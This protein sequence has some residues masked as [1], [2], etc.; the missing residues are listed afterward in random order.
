MRKF[1]I[2]FFVLFAFMSANNVNAQDETNYFLNDYFYYEITDE[3][4]AEVALYTYDYNYVGSLPEMCIVPATVTDPNTSKVYNVTT[5]KNN[6]FYWSP[7]QGI[8]FKGPI[9]RVGDQ[10]FYNCS[11]EKVVFEQAVDTIG[12]R[13]FYYDRALQDVTFNS[14]LKVLCDEAF[15]YSSVQNLTLP[16]GLDSIGER[17]FTYT[18]LKNIV[19]PEGFSKIGKYMFSQCYDLESITIPGTVKVVSPY[20]FYGC[21]KLQFTLEEGVEELGEEAFHGNCTETIVLPSTITKLGYRCLASGSGHKRIVAKMQNPPMCDG[22]DYDVYENIICDVPD[23]RLQAYI[24]QGWD[25][26]KY[27]KEISQ[28]DPVFFVADGLRYHALDDATCEL[29]KSEDGWYSLEEA[30]LTIP[31]EVTDPNTNKS[32]KVV[33]L[34]R[35]CLNGASMTSLTLPEGLVRIEYGAMENCNNMQEVNF[36]STLKE[37]GGYSFAFSGIKEANLNNGIETVESGAFVRCMNLTSAV[38]PASLVDEYEMGVDYEGNPEKIKVKG[39]LYGAFAMNDNLKAVTSYITDPHDDYIFREL[40]DSAVLT[41]PTGLLDKYCA[42]ASEIS[43]GAFDIIQDMSGRKAC[44]LTIEGGWQGSYTVNGVPVTDNYSAFLP[45]GTELTIVITPNEDIYLLD[46]IWLG[47]ENITSQ[48]DGNTIVIIIDGGIQKIRFNF[49]EQFILKAPI[50]TYSSAYGLDLTGNEDVAA[51][52]AKGFEDNDVL[53]ERVDKVYPGMGVLLVGTVGTTVP[54]VVDPDW[55][56]FT[57][58]NLMRSCWNWGNFVSASSWTS[59]GNTKNYVLT[60]DPE[61]DYAYYFTEVVTSATL[62][63]R[64]AF[65]GI[66]ESE[67]GETPPTTFN[68]K[69]TGVETGLETI[70]NTQQSNGVYDLQGRKVQ[71]ASRGLYIINGKKVLVK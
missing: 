26:F 30:P 34:G 25:R 48:L 58:E 62:D 20:A 7:L 39:L 17:C 61:Q 29:T 60:N 27:L 47:D 54:T 4:N 40:P 38:L 10:A 45:E 18:G 64:G 14:T 28:P 24:D 68:L 44:R 42:V 35:E 53:L 65:L 71:K 36:P 57:G 59:A 66:V 49:K 31:A 8:T 19:F 43:W 69:F 46:Q 23:G 55:G 3:E 5:V 13:A 12:Y 1:Y 63:V 67:L 32:Y 6:A 41:V 37:I 21:N 51:W 70:G 50:Q 16:L 15:Y 11:L 22:F 9:K 33:R 56:D 2:A 52:V